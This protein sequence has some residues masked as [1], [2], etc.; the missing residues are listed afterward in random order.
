MTDPPKET[1]PGVYTVTAPPKETGPGVYTVAD[2]FGTG[3]VPKTEPAFLE[4]QF[5]DLGAVSRKSR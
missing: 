5:S 3:T 2:P 1:G 4:V